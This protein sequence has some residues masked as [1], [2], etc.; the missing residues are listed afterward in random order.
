MEGT[1]KHEDGQQRTRMDEA[2]LG[3]PVRVV[4]NGDRLRTRDGNDALQMECSRLPRRFQA[5]ELA[6]RVQEKA[7]E[8]EKLKREADTIRR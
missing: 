1:T 5:L 4:L 3:Q 7:K 2:M 6:M 8:T